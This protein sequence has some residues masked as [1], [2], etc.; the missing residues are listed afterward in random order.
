ML[1]KVVYAG[2][3]AA[4]FVQA[5]K[6]LEALAEVKLT[7]QRVERWTK[8]VG[9]ERVAEVQRQAESY[10]A[11]PLPEQQRSPAAQVPQVACVMVDGGRIQIR[12]RHDSAGDD[13]RESKGYWRESLVGCCLSMLSQEHAQD[14]CPT[15]PATFV[16]PLR[17]STLSREIKGFSGDAE[18]ADDVPPGHPPD[19][20]DRPEVLVRSVVATRGGQ[21][22]LGERLV[23]EAYR[24]GFHAARRKAF[25][26]DGAQGNW[27]VHKKY[28]S[29]Y[30]P[31]LD[32]VHALCYVYAAA[33]T[34]RTSR[35]AWDDYVRWAQWL[36]EGGTGKLIAAVA[37]R[38]D[39]LGPP[40]DGDETS[41]AAIVAKTL[42]YLRNQ[43]SRMKYHEYRR[44]GLPITSSHI[45]STIKQIN[46]R[47][48]GTEKFW[49][50]G[51]EPLIVLAA[52]HLSETSC[53][54]QFWK[55]RRKRLQPMRCYQSAA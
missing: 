3:Q 22:A 8:R 38:A 11:L 51:A 16:D 46:R 34:G 30:T 20:D 50:Q 47:M 53:L 14:P 29:H 35:A 15:I 23:D 52:D 19:R 33:T 1:R 6:D 18:A 4:S 13:Q 31:V 12:Q 55:T 2:S 7:R 25:V 39:G 42:G 43:R 41:P 24:R 10:R 54:D 9:Q 48:K 45:E 32:F 5:T 28:F 44:L 17:M 27:S 49:D 26:A 36:W 21:Q 40:R 37:A